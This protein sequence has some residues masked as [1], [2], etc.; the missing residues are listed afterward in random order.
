MLPDRLL[1]GR[2]A[3][4]D[5][6]DQSRH[7]VVQIESSIEA[8]GEGGQVIGRVLAVLQR[9]V[10]ASQRGLEVAQHSADPQ[11]LRQ[12]SRL[13]DADDHWLVGAACSGDG[14]EATQAVD[15]DRATRCQARLGPL[16]DGFG[17][18]A[19]DQAEFEESRAVLVVQRNGGH[20][21]HLVL[22]AAAGLAA[23]ALATE[24]GIVDPRFLSWPIGKF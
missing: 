12:V 22:R 1:L 17:C 4:S 3:P 13:A 15:E 9:V 10:C 16:A 8:V 19:A 2:R 21:R 14:G 24:V 6:D 18:E 23:R 7:Q 20:E 5:V 11:E